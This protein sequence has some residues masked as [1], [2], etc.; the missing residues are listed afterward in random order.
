[1]RPEEYLLIVLRRW[2]LVVLAAIVAAAVAYVYTSAQPTTYQ[3]STQLMAVA[4]PPDYWLDLYAKNRLASYTS[5]IN[6]WD[7]VSSA[8]KTAKLN[9]DPS[10]V[11]G[12]LAVGHNPDANTVQIVMTDTDPQRAASVVNALADAF[13][14]KSVADDAQVIK[15]YSSPTTQTPAGTVQ[16]LKLE[17]PSA[18]TTP[19]GPRVKLNTAAAALLGIVFG[20]ILTFVVEYFDDTLRSEDD[21][22]RYLE[23]PTLVGIPRS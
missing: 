3:T 15:N 10:L 13:V 6:N 12:K 17:T 16:I 23:L 14:A 1:M 22:D 20:V 18:P 4:Q 9:V 7:F 19:T 21:V 8:L 2:W 11:M 5:L